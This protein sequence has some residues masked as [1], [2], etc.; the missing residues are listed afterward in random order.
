LVVRT[1]AGAV[2]VPG[3]LSFNPTSSK[4]STA[5]R[6]IAEIALVKMVAGRAG[7]LLVRLDAH[8]GASQPF[9]W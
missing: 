9:R 1:L 4:S 3:K 7:D 2:V 8:P 5:R 6:R